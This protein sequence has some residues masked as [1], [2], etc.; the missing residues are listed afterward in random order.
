[1]KKAVSPA[2]QLRY[3]LLRPYR[4]VPSGRGQIRAAGLQKRRKSL[5][6]IV[7]KSVPF[8]EFRLMSGQLRNYNKLP[9]I[10][11]LYPENRSWNSGMFLPAGVLRVISY[12]LRI[13]RPLFLWETD[14]KDH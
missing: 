5:K 2:W 9:P 4:F 1:M 11:R 13:S 3:D 8:D 10:P 6:T 14:R 7:R 12:I